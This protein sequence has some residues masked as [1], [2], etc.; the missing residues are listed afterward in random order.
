MPNQSFVLKADEKTRKVVTRYFKEKQDE[1]D[2]EEDEED[3][4]EEEEV[5]RNIY[6][7]IISGTN[8][9]FTDFVARNH[10]DV[11]AIKKVLSAPLDL[12]KYGFST[13]L[14]EPKTVLDY[15]RSFLDPS[16]IHKF[17]TN[18]QMYFSFCYGNFVDK[19]HGS[20]CEV[21][22]HCADWR[23][24]HCWNCNRCTDSTLLIV[25]LYPFLLLETIFMDVL[26]ICIQHQLARL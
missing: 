12:S 20:H 24:W 14:D 16:A 5:G 19:Q 9:C 13:E 10:T 22:G 18:D 26:F 1:E 23:S 11:E 7:H 25:F 17:P 6:K 15:M 21:C 2:E 8:T 4:E 3:E